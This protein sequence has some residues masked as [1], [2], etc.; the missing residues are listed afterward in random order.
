MATEYRPAEF[1]SKWKKVWEEQKAFAKD[2]AKN[3]RS[4]IAYALSLIHS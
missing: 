4:S 2:I 1:E 3:G